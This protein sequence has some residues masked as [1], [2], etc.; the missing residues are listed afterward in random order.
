MYKLTEN[1]PSGDKIRDA[2]KGKED[3]EF[4]STITEDADFARRLM[5]E[6]QS[7]FGGP[8]Y[9]LYNTLYFNYFGTNLL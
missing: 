1:E 5:K 6:Y 3:E 7:L 4:F 2:Y 8:K 9:G